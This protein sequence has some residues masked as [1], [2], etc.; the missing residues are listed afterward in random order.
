MF[1]VTKKRLKIC[2]K[3]RVKD[4]ALCDLLPDGKVNCIDVYNFQ[5]IIDKSISIYKKISTFIHELIHIVYVVYYGIT[6]SH[7]DLEKE[8]LRKEKYFMR[9]YGDYFAYLLFYYFPNLESSNF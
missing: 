1:V 3:E 8:I 5:I 6:G 4:I 7:R 2:L 9:K